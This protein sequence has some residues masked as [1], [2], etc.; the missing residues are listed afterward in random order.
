VN[1]SCYLASLLSIH[2][3]D[4]EHCNTDETSGR[5][6]RKR[7]EEL[8]SRKQPQSRNNGK[9]EETVLVFDSQGHEAVT[10]PCVPS[11]PQKRIV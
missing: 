5:A 8:N 4:C 6:I 11:A 3:S 7:L 10:I 2:R 9:K 1:L